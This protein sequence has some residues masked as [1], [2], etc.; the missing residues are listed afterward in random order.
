MALPTFGK[1]TSL[2]AYVEYYGDGASP[3]GQQD[4]DSLATIYDITADNTDGFA[5]KGRPEVANDFP[6][7]VQSFS[8]TFNGQLLEDGGFSTFVR[9]RWRMDGFNWNTS[10]PMNVSEGEFSTNVF[11]G[12]GNS[13]SV[14]EYQAMAYNECDNQNWQYATGTQSFTIP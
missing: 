2:E 12:F 10:M 14:I 8:A 11:Y 7:D 9:F 1:I 3:S 4:L 5:G 6:S 13:G